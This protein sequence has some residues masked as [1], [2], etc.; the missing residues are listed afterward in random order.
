MST[1]PG[2]RIFGFPVDVRPGFIV[3][4]GLFVLLYSGQGRGELG[5]WIA[6]S[7]GLFT[8]CHELGHAFAAR[9]TGAEA[10]IA[11]D[12]LAGYASFEP[13]R[14][15]K[16]WEKAG[17][18]VAGPAVQ[19]LLGTGI[20]LLMGHSPFDSYSLASRPSALAVWFAGPILGLI[21]LAP[22][23]PLDG[24]NIVMTGID[25]FLPGRSRI[26]M[27][28]FS[29]VVTVVGLIV[30]GQG[31]YPISPIFLIFPLIVQI[32]MLQHRHTQQALD[33][34]GSWQQWAASAERD[35]WTTGK[36]GRFPP[37]MV[38][39]PWFRS[40]ELA[41][42]GKYED[43]RSLLVNDFANRQSP[44]WI[45]PEAA[46]ERELEALIGLLPQPFP[47]GNQYSEYVLASML[48]RVGQFETAGKYAAES[49]GRSPG[50]M[51]AV[52]VAQCAAALGDDEL[53]VKWLRAAFASG[54][55]LA[56]LAE[57]IDRRTEF[58]HL[59]GRPDMVT[60]RHQLASST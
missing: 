32:Q 25:V 45:P 31:D 26:V 55:N 7:V 37:G 19:I 53:A 5:I 60:L 28:Y 34:H 50:T 51:P 10:S 18:S 38:A 58:A 6:G 24:G 59:R 44:N 43:A 9:A 40:A 22:I 36:P 41:R 33:E 8:L 4:L 29:I 52:I 48:T 14:V 42:V 30:L 49:Y 1:T 57:A 54:T 12:F 16:R 11:L 35:A 47:T 17:I 2:L 21:N 23:L 56:G 46:S 39:S 15:L 3:L 13:T 27:I 20:L